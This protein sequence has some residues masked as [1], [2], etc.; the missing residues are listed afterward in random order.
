MFTL[1]LLSPLFYNEIIIKHYPNNLS[2]YE[3]YLGLNWEIDT[4]LGANLGFLIKKK[5]PSSP[6]LLI[7]ITHP[8]KHP[9][10]LTQI[11]SSFLSL[12]LSNLLRSNQSTMATD[13][14]KIS[15]LQSAVANLNQIR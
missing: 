5:P 1:S 2:L 6:P 10:F 4:S 11:Y 8:F 14:E 12:S 15:Q 13:T 7:Y 3:T 9:P